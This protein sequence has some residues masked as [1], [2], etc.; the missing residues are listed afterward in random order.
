MTNLNRGGNPQEDAREAKERFN[1]VV[2]PTLEKQGYKLVSGRSTNMV[3]PNT[4]SVVIIKS[5]P[6]NFELIKSMKTVVRD[7][8]KKMEK[9]TINVL[10]TRPF[11][12]WSEK[13]SYVD[14]LKKVQRMNS[15]NGV[16]VGLETLPTVINKLES[17][18]F[19]SLIG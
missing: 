16:S 12:E 13:K 4:N 10:F 8:R 6:S 15:I 18:E 3:N 9:P 5:A 2:R 17:K 11:S 19:Y 1:K 14:A 7:F